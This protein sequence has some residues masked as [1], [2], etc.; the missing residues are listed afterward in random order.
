MNAAYSVKWYNQS[1]KFKK[2]LQ[3]IIMRAQRPCLIYLGPL[4]PLTMEHFQDVSQISLYNIT[5]FFIK[6][7]L[8]AEI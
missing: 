3:M 8:H 6:S 5:I 2:M 1:T 7:V 4:F